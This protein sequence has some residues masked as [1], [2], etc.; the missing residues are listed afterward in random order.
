LSWLVRGPLKEVSLKAVFK[1]TSFKAVFKV[2]G[3]Q[4]FKFNCSRN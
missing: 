4:L 3:V 1:K 2:Q